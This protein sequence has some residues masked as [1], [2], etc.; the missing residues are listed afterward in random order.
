MRFLLFSWKCLLRAPSLACPQPIPLQVAGLAFLMSRPGLPDVPAGP[1]PTVSGGI[2]SFHSGLPGCG[3]D[4][5][6]GLWH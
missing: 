2:T 4:W 5:H 3:G 1:K 6:T